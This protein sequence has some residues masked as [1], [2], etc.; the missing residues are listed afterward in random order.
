MSHRILYPEVIEYISSYRSLMKPNENQ[1]SYGAS[2]FKEAIWGTIENSIQFIKSSPVVG[3]LGHFC[4]DDTV[5]DKKMFVGFEQAILDVTKMQDEVQSKNC[6][7]PSVGARFSIPD[8]MTIDQ[9]LTI[10]ANNSSRP[11]DEYLPKLDVTNRMSDFRNH[12]P[13]NKL[14]AGFFAD[15]P[16]NIVTQ[17]LSQ[18]GGNIYVRYFFGI[19]LGGQENTL[20]LILIAVNANTHQNLIGSNDL[21]LERT[22]P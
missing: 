8:A 7:V 11:D 16:I 15:R 10:P 13:I 17:F 4:Y 2:L 12:V 22:F 21:M 18:N 20:R 6:V 19:T 5:S 1:L 3:S 14:A 9:F